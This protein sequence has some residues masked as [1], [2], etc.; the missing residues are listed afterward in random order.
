MRVEA[1]HLQ[2]LLTPESIRRCWNTGLYPGNDCLFQSYPGDLL[3]M[4]S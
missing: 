3:A 2:P 4:E 1:E